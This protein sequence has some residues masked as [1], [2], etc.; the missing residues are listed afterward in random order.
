MRCQGGVCVCVCVCPSERRQ[1]TRLLDAAF[2]TI[3]LAG[4]TDS[5]L[6]AQMQSNGSSKLV[7]LEIFSEHSEEGSRFVL[8]IHDS[9]Y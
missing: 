4:A 8:S 3:G 5:H 1:S 9:K 2:E 7:S 6:N